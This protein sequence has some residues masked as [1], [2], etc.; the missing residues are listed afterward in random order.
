MTGKTKEELLKELELEW[1]R[2]FQSEGQRFLIYKRLNKAVFQGSTKD[3]YDYDAID[4]W[5][6]QQPTAE[7]AYS[8]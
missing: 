6:L 1:A 8:L 3:P 4:C 5:V 2:D 7:D